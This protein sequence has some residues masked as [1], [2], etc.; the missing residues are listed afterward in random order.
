MEEK[1][2]SADPRGSTNTKRNK[3]KVLHIQTP[4][5][6]VESQRKEETLEM[7]KV[8][9]K[10]TSIRLTVDLSPA[11]EDNTFKGL[12]EKK[13]CQPRILYPAK[14]TFKNEYLTGV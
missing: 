8:I 7:C 13:N 4:N 1:H 3:Y 14:I 11:V 2:Q 9:Y 10:G 12:R 5:K 6:N